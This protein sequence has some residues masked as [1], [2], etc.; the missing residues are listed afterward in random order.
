[1]EPETNDRHLT[2]ELEAVVRLASETAVDA[3]R[4]ELAQ[5]ME[6]AHKERHRQVI[7]KTL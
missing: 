5:Q 6:N 2:P 1:M 4:Q 7:N 3:Y